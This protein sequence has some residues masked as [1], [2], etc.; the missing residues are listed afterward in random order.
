M[1][2]YGMEP[3]VPAD[4]ETRV[5]LALSASLEALKLARREAEGAGTDPARRLWTALGIVSALQGALVAALSGYDSAV[6]EAVLSPSQPDR[7]APAGFLLRRAR[8]DEYL[9]TPERVELPSSR[10]RALERVINVRNLAV[11]ALSVDVPESFAQDALVATRLIRHLVLD[12][13]A[14]DPS[15]VRVITALIADQVKALETA[16]SEM[17]AG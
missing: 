2:G 1:I 3:P 15:P 7:I 6:P 14:F 4:R 8:S 5:R 11:H 9:N 12:A 13:P 10:L 16:L 17:P